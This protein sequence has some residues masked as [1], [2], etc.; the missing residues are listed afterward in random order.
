MPAVIRPVADPSTGTFH[1]DVPADEPVE[2]GPA[3]LLAHRH[4]EV[5]DHLASAVVV[6]DLT[7]RD[8]RWAFA[9]TRLVPGADSHPVHM[10]QTVRRCR[11]AARAY[12]ERRHL[13]TPPVDWDAFAALKAEVARAQ[14]AGR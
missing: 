1:L 9:P 5:L 12:V 14:P 6:G 8:G 3:S 11:Q 2:P 10:V 4:D 7:R 13:P